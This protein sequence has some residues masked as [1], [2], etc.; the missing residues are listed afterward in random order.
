MEIFIILQVFDEYGNHLK[1][2]DLILLRLDGLS[3]QDGSGINCGLVMES[4]KKVC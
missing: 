4:K 2:N 3:I 1:E